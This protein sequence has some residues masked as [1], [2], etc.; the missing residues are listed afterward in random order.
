MSD[1]N[2]TETVMPTL[3]ALEGDRTPIVLPGN[4]PPAAMAAFDE[5]LQATSGES[6]QI[7]KFKKGRWST[8]TDQTAIALGT[9]M[10]VD[11]SSISDGHVKW[12]DKRPVASAMRRII[13]GPFKPRDEL[14]DLDED[15]WPVDPVSNKP[16]DPWARTKS[17]LLKDT[18]TWEQFTFST[19]S[20]GG[21]NCIGN[22]VQKL[23]AGMAKGLAGI[24]I[25]VLESD[26]YMHP[27]YDEVFTPLM[28]IKAWKSEAELMG[29]KPD[30]DDELNDEVPAA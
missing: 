28:P 25:V 12:I 18:E 24:P 10:A 2:S 30:L 5:Y 20:V 22:L 16:R 9:E 13:A 26:S 3:S 11:V 4:L 14:G 15:L 27:E 29:G 19:S 1:N 7:L 8:G 6:A 21:L 23:R 17:V